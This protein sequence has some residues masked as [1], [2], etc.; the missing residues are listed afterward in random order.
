MRRYSSGR[1]AAPGYN[2]TAVA[3][4]DRPVSERYQ[5]PD[6]VGVYDR[7]RYRTLGGRFNNWRT[8][9]LLRK[10]LKDLPP[11][12]LVLDVACGTG[13]IDA[14]LLEARQ[15][16]IAL[17]ISGEMLAVARGKPELCSPD[18]RF[19]RSHAAQLPCRARSA[20]AVF[21]IRFLHL[22]KRP[23]RIAVLGELARV[24]RGW[25]VVEYRSVTKPL[26]AMK[27]ALVRWATGRP[28]QRSVALADVLDELDAGG[29]V[30]ERH[31]FV[32]RW[33]SGSV[34]IVARGKAT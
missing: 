6:V 20:D 16:V 24:T 33:F 2:R 7:V 32:S 29:L 34:L 26:R 15:R 13:R 9:R 22:L 27:R 4:P 30:A 5:H 23:E 17:D 3:R 31:Y 1:V 8:H 21:S 11:G 12:G 18:L 10:I 28:G 14:C 25:V 19:V